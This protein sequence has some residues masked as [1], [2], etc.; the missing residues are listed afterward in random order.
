MGKTSQ[1]G[2]LQLAILRVLW[3]QVEATAGDVHAALHER[4]LAP[5]TIATMLKKMEARGLVTHRDEGRRFIYQP[6]VSEESV[7]REMV[8]D[9][10][11]RLFGGKVTELVNHLIAEHDIDRGELAELNRLITHAE[12]QS[13]RRDRS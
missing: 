12:R 5:T 10:T 1:L 3:A 13:R 2:N 7:T 11:D 8:A 6:A 4:G 9:L